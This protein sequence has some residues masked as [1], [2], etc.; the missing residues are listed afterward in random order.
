MC[1][2]SLIYKNSTN[3]FFTNENGYFISGMNTDKLIDTLYF[4]E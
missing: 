4:C 1:G 2:V 3:S